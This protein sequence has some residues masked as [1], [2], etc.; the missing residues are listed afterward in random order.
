MGRNVRIG[1]DDDWER[2]A[3]LDRAFEHEPRATR[4]PRFVDVGGRVRTAKIG[5]NSNGGES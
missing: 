1:S 5:A 2:E 3:R 4:R